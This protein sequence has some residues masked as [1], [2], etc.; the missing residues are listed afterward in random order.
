MKLTGHR[1]EAM[2]RRYAIVSP[3]DLQDAVRRLEGYTSGVSGYT[4]AAAAG[5]TRRI[6]KQI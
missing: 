4:A 2:Y 3:G 6:P 5:Q 1:T